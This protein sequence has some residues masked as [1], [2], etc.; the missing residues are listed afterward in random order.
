MTSIPPL[1]RERLTKRLPATACTS[2]QFS[3]VSTYAKAEEISVSAVVR[4]AL[5]LFLDQVY[6]KSVEKSETPLSEEAS[7]D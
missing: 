1:K 3:A 6:E 2:E 4:H 5:A 7:S